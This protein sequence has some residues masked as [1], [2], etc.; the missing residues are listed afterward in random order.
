MTYL[1]TR[2]LLKKSFSH[3]ISYDFVLLLLYTSVIPMKFNV[4]EIVV[5]NLFIS[6]YVVESH[7]PIN[8][9]NYVILL[10]IRYSVDVVIEGI[11]P[12]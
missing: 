11:I 6:L 9:F 8:P 10:T 12:S 1:S 3:E 2:R 4:V 5:Q 7:N